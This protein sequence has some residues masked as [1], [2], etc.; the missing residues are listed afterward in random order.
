MLATIRSAVMITCALVLSACNST[1][2]HG[3]VQR[4]KTQQQDLSSAWEHN[5]NAKDWN[6]VAGAYTADA[7]LMPPNGPVIQGRDN[8]K[9]FFVSFPPIRDMKLTLIEIDGCG[10]LAY[11]RGAYS[12]SVTI[13]NSAPIHEQG[14]YIEI[15]RKQSD[16]R[17]LIA[18]DMF[19]SDLPAK[20]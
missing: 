15:R 14:K 3:L 9:N 12:M 1:S 5:V 4:E 18:R 6:A 7:I 16:G 2:Q 19:S 11:V 8:I 10:D 13:P 17:W 20:P